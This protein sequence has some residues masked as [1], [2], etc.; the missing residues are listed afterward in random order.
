ML[1]LVFI[2]LSAILVYWLFSFNTLLQYLFVIF[3]AGG[4]YF[5]T[6]AEPSGFP[7]G[8]IFFCVIILAITFFIHFWTK[9]DIQ[10]EKP[11]SPSEQAYQDW[12]ESKIDPE[13]KNYI[14]ETYG[15]KDKNA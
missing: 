2:F 11:L 7:W 13:I 8:V 5:F 9:S 12:C 10:T 6:P 3:I 4:I 15:I 14:E 1:I